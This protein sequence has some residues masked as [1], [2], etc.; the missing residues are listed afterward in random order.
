[1][2]LIFDLHSGSLNL[3]CK[4][5]KTW[6]HGNVWKLN[7]ASWLLKSPTNPLFVQQLV[8][9]KTRKSPKLRIS[10]LFVREIYRWQLDSPHKGP[11]MWW[12]F[13]CHAVIMYMEVTDSFK[14]WTVCFSPLLYEYAITYRM[15]IKWCVG[16]AHNILNEQYI[17]WSIL[18]PLMFK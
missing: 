14:I 6:L 7:W 15:C 13:P 10:G 17:P 2:E 18:L 4:I 16:C 11:V 12:A 8:I 1:M 5:K 9:L 3:W